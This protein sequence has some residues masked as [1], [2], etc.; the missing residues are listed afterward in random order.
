MY[1]PVAQKYTGLRDARLVEAIPMI[2]LVAFILLLGI[3]PGILTQTMHQTVTDFDSFIQ[4]ITGK[5]GG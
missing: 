3:Y 1:G 2:T 5:I 4:T